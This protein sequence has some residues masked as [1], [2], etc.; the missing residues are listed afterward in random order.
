[1]DIKKYNLITAPIKLW[2]KNTSNQQT[3]SQIILKQK[4]PYNHSN[5]NNHHIIIDDM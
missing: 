4:M 2:I 1:M 3:K 5:H